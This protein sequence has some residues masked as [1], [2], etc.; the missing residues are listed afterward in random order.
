MCADWFF[1]H[2]IFEF[3]IDLFF[4]PATDPR[5]N[6]IIIYQY[7]SLVHSVKLEGALSLVNLTKTTECE[8]YRSWKMPESNRGFQ[9]AWSGSLRFPHYLPLIFFRHIGATERSTQITRIC[10]W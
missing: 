7:D 9:L 3:S 6:L 1:Q 5:K 2:T 4:S 10:E 8:E